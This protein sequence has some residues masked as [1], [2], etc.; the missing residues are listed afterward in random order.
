MSERGPRRAQAVPGDTAPSSHVEALPGLTGCTVECKYYGSSGA[1][2]R[3]PAVQEL[4]ETSS[5]LREAAPTSAGPGP[6]DAAEGDG[7]SR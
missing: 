1:A 4:G 2:S 6:G 3:A 5:G 7:G